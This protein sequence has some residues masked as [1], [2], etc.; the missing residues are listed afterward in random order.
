MGCG[1]A[2]LAMICNFHGTRVDIDK[3]EEFCQPTVEGISM[4]GILDAARVLGLRACG[5]RSGI[6]DLG[7][8]NLPIVLHWNQ[9]HFVVLYKRVYV[10][11]NHKDSL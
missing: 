9:N 11:L 3:I 10:D 4:K 2:C 5:I 8:L 7:M 6:N 1:V